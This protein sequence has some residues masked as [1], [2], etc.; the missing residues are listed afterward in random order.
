[1]VW[2]LIVLIALVV[3]VFGL[4]VS[5]TA[6]RLDRLHPRCVATAAVSGGAG[7]RDI[8]GDGSCVGHR[9]C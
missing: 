6:G 1:M 3:I 2:L 8:R 5:M 9:A 7:T 4:Y